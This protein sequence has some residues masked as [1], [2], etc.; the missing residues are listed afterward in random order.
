[1]ILIW[2]WFRNISLFHLLEQDI[3]RRPPRCHLID[4][5]IEKLNLYDSKLEEIQSKIAIAA[6]KEHEADRGELSSPNELN[7]GGKC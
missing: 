5:V 2:A 1:M 7:F 4:S 3:G 6:D